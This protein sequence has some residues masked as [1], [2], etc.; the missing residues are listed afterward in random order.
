MMSPMVNPL[1]CA[2]TAAA[3]FLLAFL[4]LVTDAIH[5]HAQDG[6]SDTTLPASRIFLPAIASPA[7]EIT[8]QENVRQLADEAPLEGA[9]VQQV[10]VSLCSIQQISGVTSPSSKR[11]LV[12]IQGLGT[13]ATTI[14]D[15]EKEWNDFVSLYGYLYKGIVY[16][17]YNRAS[18]EQYSA[19]DTGRSMWINHIPLLRDRLNSCVSLDS[20]I[21]SIDLVG[22][23]LGGSVSMEYM[24]YYGLLPTEPAAQKVSHVLTLA[25]PLSGSYWLYCANIF[26]EDNCTTRFPLELAVVKVVFGRQYFSDAAADLAG[27]YMDKDTVQ[28]RNEEYAKL[29][30]CRSRLDGLTNSQNALFRALYN[31]DDLVFTPSDITWQYNFG[32]GYHLGNTDDN[33]GHGR[34]RKQP[35]LSQFLDANI[36]GFLTST[37]SCSPTDPPPPPPPDPTSECTVAPTQ[38]GVILYRYVN[39]TGPCS[40]L[41]GSHPNLGQLAVGDNA[42]SSIRVNGE[43][44]VRLYP[45]TNF[46]GD[47]Y[48]EI[49][50]SNPNLDVT[51]LGEQYSSVE[52]S[53][54]TG[55]DNPK[56]Q[57][58]FLYGK[59]NFEGSC[60]HIQ[61]SVNDLG[62]T[63]VGDNNVSSVRINGDYQVILWE[64]KDFKGRTD[65]VNGNE[66][67]LDNRSLANLY[68]SVKLRRPIYC[69]DT[70]KEGVYLYSEKNYVGN[71]AYITSDVANL[72]TTPVGD[73]NPRSVKIV[74]NFE[75]QLFEDVNFGGLH[76]RF[77]TDQK[78]LTRESLGDQFSSVWIYPKNLPPNT[79]TLISP[80]NNNLTEDGG[81]PIL[82]WLNNGDPN[83]DALQYYARLH[84]DGQTQES[85]WI[86]ATCW[87]PSTMGPGAY[88]WEVQ[89]KDPG[90]KA[91]PW[92]TPWNFSVNNGIELVGTF[93]FVRPDLP[94][95]G[96]ILRAQFTLH[97][98]G[99]Q[100]RTIRTMLAAVRGPNCL[101]W[102]C[103]N[104]P[105]FP[106]VM[107]VTLQ[108]GEQY[109][110]DQYQAFNVEGSGYFVAPLY[111]EAGIW[112]EVPNSRIDFA[113]GPGLKFVESPRL[114]PPMPTVGKP[115]TAS[116]TL[117]NTSDHTIVLTS[118]MMAVHGPNCREWNC[119]PTSDFWSDFKLLP[120]GAD[121][122][123]AMTRT[124]EAGSGYLAMPVYQPPY[125][126]WRRLPGAET[127]PFAV[128][129]TALG[130]PPTDVSVWRVLLLVYPSIDAAFTDT[131]G[132]PKRLTY[133]MA[134]SEIGDAEQAFRQYAAL[135]YTLSNGEVFIEPTIVHVN[136]PIT[137]LT[138]MGTNLYWPSP[139]DTKTEIDRVAPA[140]KYDS[141]LV[142]WPQ[143]NSATGQ[144]IPSSG[145][146]LALG[147]DALVN[148]ALYA[149][150][151]NAPGIAWSIPAVGEPWLQAW[152]SGAAAF[153]SSQGYR[154]PAGDVGGTLSHGYIN[155]P[156][157]GWLSYYRDLMTG[158][159]LENGA[160]NRSSR[161]CMA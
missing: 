1:S 71:C 33:G 123:Y 36:R 102:T 3:V 23:S 112:R 70:T 116:F 160:L 146:W 59:P 11:L 119:A 126:E 50:S 21:Q 154:M 13:S 47:G 100:V 60:I 67:S 120:P 16:F 122:R 140:D 103:P 92:T 128:G 31:F 38:P 118:A 124:F 44:Q 148:G 20:S 87:Q 28:H 101:D 40:H 26:G 141:I 152:L 110:Y 145:W 72:G 139:V 129:G 15:S 7:Q 62:V 157:L 32:Y 131:D 34:I 113:V 27:M 54:R 12:L 159:V 9:S 56:A 63:A 91:S 80:A 55:C 49:S 53:Q 39:Y 161:R 95:V 106:A 68:S 8:A 51:P 93:N 85:G 78:D 104:M 18:V 94:G 43:Y 117:R 153:Y 14:A 151:A 105:D 74:G 6:D 64:D 130:D 82:C 138:A 52:I 121:W 76:Y 136:R 19:D 133:S 99:N 143:T 109:T 114:D 58:V 144:S 134:P 83:G 79:P 46:T 66:S 73:N 156:E 150:V 81:V 42:V 86:S 2:R 142:L 97:N 77:G 88:S 90:G 57:G 22:H 25:T 132:T 37:S 5:V 41:A 158:G 96:E 75:V 89:A 61:T 35:W 111:Q 30:N 125:G 84:K 107:N 45:N 108:P 4:F 147:P 127:I 65:E 29:F 98:S 17:S 115:V 48:T 149:T 69:T 137:T 155:S 24:K 10:D 135:A